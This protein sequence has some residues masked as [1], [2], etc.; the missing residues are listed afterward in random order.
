ME[1]IY[2]VFKKTRESVN[3]GF[4]TLK[5]CNANNDNCEK[6]KNEGFTNN[7]ILQEKLNNLGVK[8]EELSH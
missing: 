6:E 3:S 8:V 2:L 7:K 4:A 5:V 1:K